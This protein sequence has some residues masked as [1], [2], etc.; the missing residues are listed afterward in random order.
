LGNRVVKD[1][2]DLDY[3]IPS[4]LQKVSSKFKSSKVQK[5]NRVR[6]DIKKSKLARQKMILENHSELLSD[7]RKSL[8]IRDKSG[9]QRAIM[10]HNPET[11]EV[12]ALLGSSN[13]SQGL[14]PY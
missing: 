5:L 13:K 4:P 9:Q 3:E 10:R 6:A 1:F 8:E 2:Y 7:R 11:I 12:G 14:C